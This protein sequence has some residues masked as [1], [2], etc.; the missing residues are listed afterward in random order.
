[1]GIFSISMPYIRRFL[2][3]IFPNLLGSRAFVSDR[4][5]PNTRSK[6]SNGNVRSS[7]SSVGFNTMIRGSAI[8]KTVDTVIEDKSKED[9]EIQLVDVEMQRMEE[10]KISWGVKSAEDTGRGMLDKGKLRSLG[11]HCL[12]QDKSENC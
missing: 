7:K 3:R 11:T 9:D 5:T 6:R 8:M 1:V 10:L 4:R 2:A 12:R